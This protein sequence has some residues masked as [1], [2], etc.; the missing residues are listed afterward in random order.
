MY[1]RFS[2]AMEVLQMVDATRKYITI[3]IPR[4]TQ[5]MYRGLFGAPS[6]DAA[7]VSVR[8]TDADRRFIDRQAGVLGISFIEFVRWSSVYAAM[9]IDKLQKEDGYPL[10][11]EKVRKVDMTE[12]D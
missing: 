11:P 6:T 12:Y 8:W 3:P 4:M 5:Y 9:E 2:F 10:T 7:P 1:H